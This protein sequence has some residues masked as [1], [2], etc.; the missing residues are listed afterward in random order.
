MRKSIVFIFIIAL[1]IAC[2]KDSNSSQGNGEVNPSE[3]VK[4]GDV[5]CGATYAIINGYANLNTI[6]IGE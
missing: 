2:G 3:V 6:N 5:E 4:T 1:F